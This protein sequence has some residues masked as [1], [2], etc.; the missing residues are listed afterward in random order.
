MA[1][2]HLYFRNPEIGL[3]E[4]KSRI[5][6]G[7]NDQEDEEEKDY[8]FMAEIFSES[9]DVFNSDIESRHNNRTI[10]VPKHFDLIEIEFFGAFDQ[11]IF[12]S[13]YYNTFGLALMHLSL[14]NRKALFA[15]S[16]QKKFDHFFN[17]INIFIEN[18]NQ[19]LNNEF[20]KKIL[21]IKDF[22]LYATSDMFRN[23][24]DYSKI[25]LSFLGKGLIEESTINP[26]KEKFV[27][28]L[29]SNNIENEYS[30]KTAELYDISEQR[31]LEILNNF[32]FIYASCS[33]SGAI[34]RPDIY[35][36]P[37][38]EFGFEITNESADLPIIGVIDT[39][40]SEQTPLSS[41]MVG[42]NGEF[43]ATGTGSF[44]DSADHGTGVA[45]F[46]AFGEKLIPDYRGE[47]ETDA[48]LLPI[49]ILDTTNGDISQSKIIEFIR[50]AH[51]DYGVKIF[52]LT[53]GYSNFPLKDNEEFSSYAMMLDALTAELDILIFI[54]T[55]NNHLN[56]VN[57]TDYPNLFISENANIA[58]P[59]ES[60]NNITIG[61]IA[62]NFRDDESGMLSPSG[63]FPAL[64]SRKLHYDFDNE[65]IFNNSNR[66]TLLRKPDVLLQGG[67]YTEFNYLG[68]NGFDHGGNAG[69]EIL[70]ADLHERTYFGIGT[71]Y[72][73]PIAA[74]MAAKL[75]KIY[76]EL[77]MQT[78]K[79]LI[80]NGSIEPNTG[81]QLDSFSN[82]LKKRIIGYGTPNFNSLAFSND[83]K[84]TLIV[85]DEIYPNYVK[86]FSLI[87]P[88]HL[89]IA[90]RKNGL[91]KVTST[92]CFKFS[93][94]DDN[95]LLY[96]PYHVTYAIGK[97]LDL[98]K[99]K[100][101]A[102][103]DENGKVKNVNVPDGYNGNS[104]ANI[105][106][107]SS[108]KGWVQDYYYKGKIV[109]NVQ[110]TSFGV[111]KQNIIDENNCLKIAVNS[112]FHKLL[113]SAEQEPYNNSI[114][115][116]IAITIEQIPLKNE[117][118]PSLY[119]ELALINK[120]DA[121]TE[122][123]LEAEV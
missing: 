43:D 5:G 110:K 96:C 71:S 93:P 52:T 22:K 59:A 64:Y 48:K 76:P 19:D 78:I 39:G 50:K 66:N 34:I 91:L 115:Y 32:D 12:E 37:Q 8:S 75:I 36:I 118:L 79:S 60:M 55:S 33:G 58:P 61:A 38:R 120:L 77:N 30:N 104:S 83:N 57:H 88:K 67:D 95:Q 105:K 54:S 20:D 103:T 25:H 7:G 113:T 80:I 1:K 15:I 82:N 16:D 121:I 4:Y 51:I 18:V 69:L 56:N 3:V 102:K 81:S 86:M 44:V 99:F 100:Q 53:I 98:N 89:N 46:A 85:E 47:I 40:I 73:A 42:E 10:E 97:N 13:Y 26:Q 119:N 6:G 27:E 108:A 49:K 111:A 106:L 68:E 94:K 116:S 62:N 123:V 14:F 117:V 28:Y 109:S 87:I 92:L 65:D 122:L 101:V 72:S 24:A 74:N 9:R 90:K 11:P 21:F 112:A 70:S 29:E 35:N 84:V 17:Q 2:T 45:A 23:I 107:N 41:I 63:I 31:L 114:P